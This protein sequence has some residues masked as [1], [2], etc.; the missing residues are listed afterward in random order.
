VAVSNRVAVNVAGDGVY[1][2]G[3]TQLEPRQ[4]L[5]EYMKA[6]GVKTVFCVALMRD[7]TLEQLAGNDGIAYVHSPMRAGTSPGALR[8]AASHAKRL[9]KDGPIMLVGETT[10]SSAVNRIV[11]ELRG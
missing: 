1:V 8:A 7:N 11:K 10:S 2:I 3:L 4:E 6:R 9:R 5:V